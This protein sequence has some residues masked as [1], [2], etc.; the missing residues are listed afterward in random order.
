MTIHFPPNEGQMCYPEPVRSII[1]MF[2][3][4]LFL[5]TFLLTATITIPDTSSNHTEL[6]IILQC[7]YSLFSSGPLSLGKDLIIFS[8]SLKSQLSK[9][10]IWF[11]RKYQTLKCLVISQ[12]SFERLITIFWILP[13]LPQRALVPS[14]APFVLCTFLNYAFNFTAS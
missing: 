13:W 7:Y 12:G 14:F 10:F 6:I 8:R 3:P 4:S 11:N 2:F 9:H 1:L 5:T